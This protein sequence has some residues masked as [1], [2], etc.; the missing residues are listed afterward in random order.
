MLELWETY[1]IWTAW[2]LLYMM[3]IVGG[4]LIAVAYYTYAERK[5]MGGMQRRQGPDD[6]WAV[7]G[8]CNRLLMG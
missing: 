2:T 7:W 4:V 5:V 8:C 6:G 1:G 3:L